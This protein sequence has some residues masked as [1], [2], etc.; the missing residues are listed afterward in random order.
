MRYAICSTPHAR[1]RRVT[2]RQSN[3]GAAPSPPGRRNG[4]NGMSDA[5]SSLP[6]SGPALSQAFEALV[7]TFDERRVRYAIIGGIATIQ[8]TRVRTTDDIDALLTVPQIALPGLFET[9]Q[10]RGF[11]IDT[12][13]SIREFRDDGLTTVRY[14]GVLIDLMR[15]VLPVYAHVLDRAIDAQV[16]GR[17]VRVSSAEGLIVMKLIAMRP[18]D[19]VDVRDLLGAYAG[20]LDLDF[21]RAELDTCTRAE[22]PRRAKFEQWVRDVPGE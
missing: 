3:A 18:Q 11:D 8:H 2:P 17:K 13:K 1:W 4:S 5:D 9:L 10:A 20:R 16:L 7:T 22:D 21:I 19:E 6:P 14:K 12:I 15:P